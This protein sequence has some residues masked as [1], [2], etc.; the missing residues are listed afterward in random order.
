MPTQNADSMM[1]SL[2]SVGSSIFH[3]WSGWPSRFSS[4]TN[5][6]SRNTSHEPSARM[7]SFGISRM[8]T[9]SD[10]VGRMNSDTPWYC[11]A[12][13]LVVLTSSRM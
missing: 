1:R 8:V 7:P 13:S 3:A 5:T 10:A 12:T 2:F 9:P 6:S 11:L 4:A